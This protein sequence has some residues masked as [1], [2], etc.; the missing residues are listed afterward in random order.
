[1]H[2]SLTTISAKQLRKNATPKKKQKQN[3]TAKKAPPQKKKT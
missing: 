2:D 3:Q 1:M